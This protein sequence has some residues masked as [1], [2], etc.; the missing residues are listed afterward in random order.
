MQAVQG[1]STLSKTHSALSYGEHGFIILECNP[2]L[3]TK[4]IVNLKGRS[5]LMDHKW[6]H[7][8]MRLKSGFDK[9]I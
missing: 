4:L 8:L 5:K 9:K 6:F 7:G 1:S 3:Q 2:I